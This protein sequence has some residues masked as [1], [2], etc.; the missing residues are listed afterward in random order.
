MQPLDTRAYQAAQYLYPP[1][2]RREYSQE[3][4]RVFNE[5]RHEQVASRGALWAF[6]ARM[7]AD[8][9]STIVWQWIGTGWPLVMVIS[10]MSMLYPLVA[11]SALVSLERSGPAVL[12]IEN[13]DADVIA[14]TLLAAIVLVVIA[15]TIILTLWFTRPLLYRRRT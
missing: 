5:A 10:M 13:P 12:S 14:L 8:L 15:T 1:A 7:S 9:A 3:I 11:A 6:R 2:F 4:V